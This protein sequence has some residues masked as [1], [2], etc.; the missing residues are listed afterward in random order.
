MRRAFVCGSVLL[1]ILTVA[2]AGQDS[3]RNARQ[4]INESDL[5]CSFLALEEAP[6][7]KI[8]A[9]E[10][11]EERALLIEGDLFVFD[12]VPGD[13]LASGQVLTILE[14]G[15]SVKVTERRARPVIVAFQR[16]KAKIVILDDRTARARVEKACGPIGI[17]QFLVPFLAGEIVKGVDQG[18]AGIEWNPDGL[19][20]V[21]LHLGGAARQAGPGQMALVELGTEQGI[22]AGQQLT[23]FK[24]NEKNALWQGMANVIVVHPGPRVSVVKIL[25]GRDALEIGDRV[26]VK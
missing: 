25:S 6:T 10:R 9:A 1:T 12:R 15:E 21:V 23:V 22:R 17:G 7:L 2:A 16:G 24:A 8:K 14:L 20:G 5:S 3:L 13:G 4:I 11:M 26:Q 19:N 18:F